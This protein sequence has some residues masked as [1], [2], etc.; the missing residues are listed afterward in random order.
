MTSTAIL[1]PARYGSTRFPGKPTALL[2]GVPMIR[3]VYDACAA[4]DMHVYALTDD[5][6]V[7]DALVGDGEYRSSVLDPHHYN[8]GTER[9]AAATV[10]GIDPHLEGFEHVINVQGDMP[11]VTPSMIYTIMEMLDAGADVATLYTDLDP[12]LVD[13]PSVVK[14]IKV[15]DHAQWF[16]RGFRYGKRHLGIY[17]YKSKALRFFPILKQPEEENIESLEQLRWIKNGWKIK[18]AWTEFDGVEINTPE[19]IEQWN[20]KKGKI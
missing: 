8:N 10:N 11:D 9:C 19:D 13:D 14:M 2:D 7:V 4:T 20:N 15:V 16:G 1:I 6:R 17:G 3:R 18:V 12:E 5:Q